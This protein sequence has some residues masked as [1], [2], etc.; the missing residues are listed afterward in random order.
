[1]NGDGNDNPSLVFMGYAVE[2][3]M[4]PFLWPGQSLHVG[5]VLWGASSL[6]ERHE[7]ENWRAGF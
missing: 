3:F 4:V 5:L 2:R 7:D 6:D 1:L